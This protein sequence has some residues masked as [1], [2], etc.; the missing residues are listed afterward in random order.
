MPVDYSKYPKDWKAIS[1]AIRE[2]SGGQCEC[3]GECGLHKTNP[4]PRRCTEINGTKAKFAKGKIVLTVAHLDHSTTNNVPSNLK[5]LCQRCH[6]RYDAPFRKMNRFT[7]RIHGDIE[8][9]VLCRGEFSDLDGCWEWIGCL[10]RQGYGKV[11]INAK[12]DYVHRYMMAWILNR[13]LLRTEHV[14]HL[15]KNR[16]CFRP[17]HLELV[18]P[19]ENT[20]R[21]DSTK[22]NGSQVAEIRSLRARGHTVVYLGEL[23]H[24]HYTHISRICRNL[25]RPQHHKKNSAATRRAKALKTQP[26]LSI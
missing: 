25:R 1:K 19:G 22:L 10:S 17:S 26:E 24:V 6:N 23:F 5:A 15:C 18:T 2:R 4:G 16:K 3:E 8:L 7:N 9:R 12:S 21:G 11:R 20:R 13:P 14:D